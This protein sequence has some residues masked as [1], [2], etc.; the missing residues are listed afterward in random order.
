MRTIYTLSFIALTIA[1]TPNQ[2]QE[3]KQVVSVN[4]VEAST[5]DS[6]KA[7]YLNKDYLMG[8]FDPSTHQ[9]FS[10]I[11]SQ[12]TEKAEIYMRKDAYE[13]FVQMAEHAKSD[14]ITF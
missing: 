12:Y 6:T 5:A 1:C 4:Q 11:A 3:E 9:D 7:T 14:G 2:N 8:K 13:A 10:K